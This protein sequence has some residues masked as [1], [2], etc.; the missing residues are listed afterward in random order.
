MYCQHCGAEIPDNSV[1]CNHC[2]KPQDTAEAKASRKNEKRKHR[3]QKFI[4][5]LL[6]VAILGTLVYFLRPTP[7]HA[8]KRFLSSMQQQDWDTAQKYYSGNPANIGVPSASTFDV[9]GEGGGEF[10]QKLVDKVMDF[11]YVVNDVTVSEDGKEATAE[12]TFTTYDFSNFMKTVNQTLLDHSTDTIGNAFWSLFGKEDTTEN[13]TTFE[14][15]EK[16]LDALTEKNKKTTTQLHLKKTQL[17][18]WKVSLLGM[19]QLDALS[20]GLYGNT[21]SSISDTVAGLLPGVQSSESTTSSDTADE[22]SGFI[23]KVS[24]IVKSATQAG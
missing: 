7:E 18:R 13:A 5:F 24:E 14:L 8:T 21:I 9:L 4:I 3:I 1:F 17:G 6:I 23:S 22:S 20:G 12:V 19:K 16:D 11:D 15:L 2:G 10:Y